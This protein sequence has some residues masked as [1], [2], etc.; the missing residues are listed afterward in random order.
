M[1]PITILTRYQS[2][3]TYV[4]K[5]DP[6]PTTAGPEMLLISDN[7]C[8]TEHDCR[9]WDYEIR[10]LQKTAD[11]GDWPIAVSAVYRYDDYAERSTEEFAFQVA[12]PPV[13]FAQMLRCALQH[14]ASVQEQW[15]TERRDRDS[16][17]NPGVR[18][19]LNRKRDKLKVVKQL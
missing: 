6:P 3:K 1:N 12:A 8:T 11:G 19:Y 15:I 17:Q 14:E 9:R 16:S 4:A 2:G 10:A 13:E 5:Y 18:G 7:E